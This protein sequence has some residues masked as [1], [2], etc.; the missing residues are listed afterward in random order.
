MHT[1]ASA[2][3]G[4]TRCFL[5]LL[6]DAPSRARLRQCRE[7][8]EHPTGGT[9]RGLRWVEPA[10]LHLTLRFFG[11]ASSGQVEHMQHML[12]G[13][14]RVLPTIEPRR[15]AIWPNRTRPRLLVLEL[16]A[17]EALQALAQE[18][19][20]LARKCGFEPEPR[21]FKAHL[22]LARLRPGCGCALAMPPPRAIA[23]ESLALVASELRTSGARYRP[24]AS[25]A[26]PSN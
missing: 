7:T 12:P 8:F 24:L 26:L 14:A 21:A 25:V 20:A 18:C 17:T 6:P 1:H 16:E 3:S 11:A 23:F 2:D 9:P 4:S 5:A 10:A 22:T 15:H 13:L 19:E